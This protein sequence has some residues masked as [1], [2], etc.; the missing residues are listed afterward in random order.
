[1]PIDTIGCFF[2]EPAIKSQLVS[3]F[4]SPIPALNHGLDLAWLN[5]DAMIALDLLHGVVDAFRL[6]AAAAVVDQ[7]GAET[8]FQAVECGRR[9]GGKVLDMYLKPSLTTGYIV[10]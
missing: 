10:K 9:Y 8:Q 3:Q 6:D 2:H 4:Y 1:M 5:D 7:C